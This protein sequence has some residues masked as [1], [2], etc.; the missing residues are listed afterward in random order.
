MNLPSLPVSSA[1][2]SEIYRRSVVLV[3]LVLR[4]RVYQCYQSNQYDTHFYK[5][6]SNPI[7]TAQ[8]CSILGGGNCTWLPATGWKGNKWRE[9]EEE[10]IHQVYIHQS[11]KIL[12]NVTFPWA[13][14]VMEPSQMTKCLDSYKPIKNS[15]SLLLD[16]REGQRCIF[17]SCGAVDVNQNLYDSDVT[18]FHT[19]PTQHS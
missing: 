6:C 16:I 2:L 12:K 17:I 8:G 9:A 13:Y 7:P 18:L 11:Q 19:W 15:I 1:P 10:L 14:T 5:F 4:P 3:R